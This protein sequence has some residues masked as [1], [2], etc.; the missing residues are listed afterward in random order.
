M[1]L[2]TR[3][4]L[5]IIPL[6]IIFLFSFTLL[7]NT[8]LFAL[9][10]DKK[11]VDIVVVEQPKVGG[12]AK[13]GQAYD[14][15]DEN[16]E[17][18][19]ETT[20]KNYESK[21]DKLGI[22]H[23]LR[24]NS[25]KNMVDNI[26]GVLNEDECIQ[27]LTLVGHGSPGNISVGDGLTTEPGNHINGNKEEWEKELARLKD[28]FCPGGSV[29]LKGCNV[30]SCDKGAKKLQEIADALGVP[31]SG[32]TGITYADCSSEPGSKTQTAQPSTPDK[33]NDP[34][35]CIMSPSDVKKLLEESARYDGPLPYDPERVIGLSIIPSGT[36]LSLVDNPVFDAKPG[37]EAFSKFFD[38]IHFGSPVQ[39]PEGKLLLANW[40]ALIIMHFDDGSIQMGAFLND[41]DYFQF[42]AILDPQPPG[43]ID[44][45]PPYKPADFLCNSYKMEEL[46]E[47]IC[48]AKLR[49]W[50]GSSDMNLIATPHCGYIKLTWNALPGAARYFIYRGPGKGQEYPM[51]IMDFPIL[52]TYYI[53]K[54]DLKPNQEYCYIVKAVDAEGREFLT[55]NEA[56]VIFTCPEEIQ[57]IT[58]EDCKMTLK[59]QVDNK[60]YW[61][62][63]IQ[64]GPMDVSPVI[65]EQRVFLMARYL[66]EETG[67]FVTWEQAT[68]TVIIKRTDGVE[69]R[70][71]IGNP[72]ASVGGQPIQI[73]PNNPNVVPFL[74]NNRTYVALRFMAYNLGA[75]G[76]NEILWHGDTRI[77]ELRF[78]DPKCKWMCGCIRYVGTNALANIAEFGFFTDCHTSTVPMA[79]IPLNMKD[80]LLNL[81]P[82]E[83]AM[84]YPNQ[85]Y[86]CAEARIDET[87]NLTAW[88]ATPGRYPNCCDAEKGMGLLRIYMPPEA[89][90]ETDIEIFAVNGTTQKQQAQGYWVE[91]FF[92]IYCELPCPGKYKVVPTNPNGTFI[93]ESLM[94]NLENCC[95]NI[96]EIKFD[97]VRRN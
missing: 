8:S 67:A 49:K 47:G 28:K 14:D 93:P 82:S 7:G 34:P 33:K 64:K 71:Q 27:T 11:P 46:F 48:D 37:D 95:P 12:H 65:R 53:D 13:N 30:G 44:P 1:V 62:N 16:G 55:S 38:G 57:P 76:P 29:T 79:K 21:K 92:D 52:E 86:Y 22:E 91:S 19:L 74:E 84:K 89:G 61:K 15:I 26:L 54:I 3:K 4:V 25:V 87:G 81:T 56:C 23:V 18:T 94:I 80:R 58:E 2:K 40:D 97:F 96:T 39:Q 35:P 17:T 72:I 51:P 69:I 77:A 24:A 88:R 66:A 85:N 73:D 59:Y 6:L 50:E 90:K 60:F 42:P 45:T 43:V 70:M 68:K 41:F 78:K 31:A 10:A 83:Y 32:N 75:T 63:D 36:P 9:F 20:A 5:L